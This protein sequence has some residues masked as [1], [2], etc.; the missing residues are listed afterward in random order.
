M[1]KQI[2][3]PRRP[4]REPRRHQRNNPA[5]F[6][7]TCSSIGNSLI[8]PNFH[9]TRRQR[10]RARPPDRQI[11]R[12]CFNVKQTRLGTLLDLPLSTRAGAHWDG[13]EIRIGRRVLPY[14][15]RYARPGYE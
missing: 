13:S 11:P 14:S 6:S 1:T 9:G 12:A 3:A 2:K 8:V 15:T 7:A 10:T 5:H 4:V